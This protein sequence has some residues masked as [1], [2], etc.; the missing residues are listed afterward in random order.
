MVPS[1]SGWS[2][3]K[4]LLVIGTVFVVSVG[5]FSLPT[6]ICGAERRCEISF[7]GADD[8]YF[9]AAGAI[10]GPFAGKRRRVSKRDLPVQARRFSR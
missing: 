1:A 7:S 8:L 6:D 4:L 3:R 10:L 2:L 5:V 9:R